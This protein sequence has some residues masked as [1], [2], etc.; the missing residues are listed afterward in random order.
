VEGETVLHTCHGYA[1][2]VRD[3]PA[4]YPFLAELAACAVRQVSVEAA[5]PRLDLSVLRALGDKVIVLGVLDLGDPAVESA[6]QVAE[7]IRAGL[8]HVDP[9]R[10]VLAPDCGMKY[11]TRTTAFGKLRALA[12]GAALVRAELDGRE[13]RGGRAAPART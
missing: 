1:A 3:K 13:T 7:R 11:L 9:E 5:Q 12:Q 8:E 6:E 10:L 4:A 2:V